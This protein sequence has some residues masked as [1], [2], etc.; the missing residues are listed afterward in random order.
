M[1]A[2][3][4]KINYSLLN[5]KGTLIA[6]IVVPAISLT[7]NRS[8]LIK[9]FINVDLPAFGLPSIATFFPFCFG[10]EYSGSFSSIFDFSKFMLIEC[11]ALISI[12]S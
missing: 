11:S 3:S 2:V 8:S 9:L 12:V 6:S 7:I 5:S 1:P 4:I 10:V